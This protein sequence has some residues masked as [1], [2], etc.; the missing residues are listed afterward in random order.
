MNTGVYVVVDFA[1]IILSIAMIYMALA[2]GG[3][4]M[5]INRLYSVMATAI[6][7][8]LPAIHVGNNLR[9][10]AQIAI[11][12]N[13]FVFGFSLIA[14]IF[15]MKMVSEMSHIYTISKSKIYNVLAILLV[16][17]SFTPPG[18]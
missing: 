3:Y 14:S 8:W 12:A 5:R 6:V 15:G 4:K 13:Y 11:I 17:A 9:T 7:I 10:P 16:V 2:N 1:T 18:W